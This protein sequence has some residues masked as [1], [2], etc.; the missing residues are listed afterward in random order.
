MLDI[1]ECEACRSSWTWQTKFDVQNN[2]RK[3]ARNMLV[4]RWLPC[5]NETYAAMT[6]LL[7]TTFAKAVSRWRLN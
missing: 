6:W 4:E 1:N 5:N 7:L 2:W 3:S